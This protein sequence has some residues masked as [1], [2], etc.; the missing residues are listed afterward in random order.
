MRSGSGIIGSVVTGLIVAT[1]GLLIEYKSGWFLGNAT[2]APAS[3]AL[4]VE[5]Q[6][7]DPRTTEEIGENGVSVANPV[8]VSPVASSIATI[9]VTGRWSCE[10]STP[11]GYLFTCTLDLQLTDQTVVTGK[12]NWTL[13]LSPRIEEQH[14]IGRS[15][16]EFVRGSFDP[17]NRVLMFQGYDKE[18]HYGVIALDSYRLTL[19]GDAGEIQGKTSSNGTWEGV[20]IARRSELP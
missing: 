14:L 2:T 9:D 8:R 10:W 19:S 4:T 15:A 13:K 6:E 18:D 20:F 17:R 5:Q 11:R 1:M 7:D 12:I 16:T 3:S